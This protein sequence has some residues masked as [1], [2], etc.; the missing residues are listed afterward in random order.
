MGVYFS[1]LFEQ[2]EKFTLLSEN[3]VHW[4]KISDQF[5]S[6]D[7]VEQA[8]KRAGIESASLIIG[9]HVPHF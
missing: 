9:L 6:Y 4:N 2:K 7:Q 8:L 3:R 5:T 1:S